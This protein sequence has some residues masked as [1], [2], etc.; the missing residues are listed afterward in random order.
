MRHCFR[1]WAQI[2]KQK[3]QVSH[4]DDCLEMRFITNIPIY[5]SDSHDTT[6]QGYTY[7]FQG[8]TRI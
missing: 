1:Y 6:F 2:S 8:Y 7:T 4:G 5:P 3:N